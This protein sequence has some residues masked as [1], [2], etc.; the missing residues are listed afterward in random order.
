MPSDNIRHAELGNLCV[1]ELRH[2]FIYN[3]YIKPFPF[4]ATHHNIHHSAF[5]WALT[6]GNMLGFKVSL[7]TGNID[8]YS[9]WTT[10]SCTM[11]SNRQQKI[12]F[13]ETNV[14]CTFIGEPRKS[15]NLEEVMCDRT[16]IYTS[17]A[18]TLFLHLVQHTSLMEHPLMD[19]KRN[20][21]SEIIADKESLVFFFSK[22]WNCCFFLQQHQLYRL[23]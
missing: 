3:T 17:I 18:P 9:N 21:C 13:W 11:T 4:W 23:W 20:R 6:I 7:W 12:F 14:L 19:R 2:L 16:K 8:W 22:Q 5:S 10:F 1:A 15:E